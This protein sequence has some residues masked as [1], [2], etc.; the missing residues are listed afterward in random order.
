MSKSTPELE[1]SV[2]SSCDS[3]VNVVVVVQV[4][5]APMLIDSL[6]GSLADVSMSVALLAP[7]SRRSGIEQDKLSRRLRDARLSAL[8]S[9]Q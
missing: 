3:V 6:S 1:P 8:G 2:G 4:L 9:G 5:V 7:F